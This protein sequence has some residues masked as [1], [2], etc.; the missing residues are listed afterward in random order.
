MEIKCLCFW[1]AA[2]LTA[3]PIPRHCTGVFK[4]KCFKVGLLHKIVVCPAE[5]KDVIKYKARQ[6]KHLLSQCAY[7]S[8][9]LR[10]GSEEQIRHEHALQEHKE[11]S[12]TLL[13]CRCKNMSRKLVVSDSEY[14]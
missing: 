4:I 14:G 7:C 2:T 1:S 12:S 11:F 3:C 6:P 5:I 13:G 9:T 10:S 8:K